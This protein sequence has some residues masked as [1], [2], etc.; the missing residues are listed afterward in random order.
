M[1]R[2]LLLAALAF[3]LAPLAVQPALT[4]EDFVAIKQLNAAYVF[5]IDNCSDGGYPYADLYVDDGT[6]GV[7]Q[8]WG[9]PGS[10]WAAGREALAKAGGGDG[11]GVC[12]D[13]KSMPGYGIH[14]ITADLVITPTATGASGRSVLFTSGVEGVPTRMRHDG[15]YEDSYVKTAKGWRFKTRVHVWPDI[16]ERLKNYKP[17]Q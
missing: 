8:V 12:R 9:D 10:V 4:P 14:H 3:P 15:G 7:S 11:K 6:F 13:P 5:A 2:A 16:P 17:A 1:R